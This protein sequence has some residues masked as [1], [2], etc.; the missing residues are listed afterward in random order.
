MLKNN[1]DRSRALGFCL[2]MN[3]T[4]LKPGTLVKYSNP[5]EGE[6]TFVFLVV[7]DNGDRVFIEDFMN[8]GMLKPVELVAREDVVEV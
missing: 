8:K 5:E 2:S 6:E 7:E 4:T 3:S 1:V